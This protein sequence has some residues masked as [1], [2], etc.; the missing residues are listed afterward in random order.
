MFQLF[1]FCDFLGPH[2]AKTFINCHFFS[3]S[4]DKWEQVCLVIVVLSLVYVDSLRCFTLEKFLFP[5]NL[6]IIKPK[7][8]HHDISVL[9]N[10]EVNFWIQ[11]SFTLL[12]NSSWTQGQVC[13]YIIIR[14]KIPFL[15]I[16]ITKVILYFCIQEF[17]PKTHALIWQL[18]FPLNLLYKR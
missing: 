1:S 10:E 2:F 5:I 12:K 6:V 11:T 14:K 3:P 4:F 13:F 15:S 8:L 17:K 18:V 7:K 9:G 16:H